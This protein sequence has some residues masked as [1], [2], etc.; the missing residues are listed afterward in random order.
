M[1]GTSSI[2]ALGEQAI[3]Q[4]GERDLAFAEDHRGG[5]AAQVQLGMIGG[6][7]SRDDDRHAARATA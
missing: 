7:G 2:D 5:A 3:G 1:P 6:I 4:V